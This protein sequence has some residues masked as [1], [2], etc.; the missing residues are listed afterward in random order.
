MSCGV[1]R[2]RSLDPVLLWLWCRLAATAPI[3]PLAWEPPYA[4]GAALEKAKINK[5]WT[6]LLLPSPPPSQ[7]SYALLESR[8]PGPGFYWSA[9]RHHR[10]FSPVSRFHVLVRAWLL[11]LCRVSLGDDHHIACV[12]VVC[13][14]RMPS[15][16]TGWP[17]LSMCIRSSS[18]DTWVVSFEYCGQGGYEHLQTCLFGAPVFSLLLEKY[19]R[20]QLLGCMVSVCLRETAT[21]FIVQ[22]YWF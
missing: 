14:S 22:V 17:P 20:E 7:F 21:S 4:T 13:S 19:L 10:L 15:I 12:S 18:T 9:F 3:Q 11:L 5:R 1:G 16:S 8:S 2:R 6:C